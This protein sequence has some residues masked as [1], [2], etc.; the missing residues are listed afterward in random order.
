[1]FQMFIIYTNL[2]VFFLVASIVPWVLLH[3]YTWTA[4]IDRRSIMHDFSG[5]LNQHLELPTAFLTASIKIE[6]L[7]SS[8]KV[9]E[10]RLILL[11]KLLS[12][13]LIAKHPTNGTLDEKNLNASTMPAW[14]PIPKARPLVTMTS[15]WRRKTID[16]F[17]HISLITR[18]NI[19]IFKLEIAFLSQNDII[20]LYPSIIQSIHS[21]TLHHW[22]LAL[23]PRKTVP[24]QLCLCI[25]WMCHTGTVEA[26]TVQLCQEACLRVGQNCWEIT[27]GFCS[28]CFECL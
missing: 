14:V 15:A 8:L 28:F 16:S 1:M 23:Q 11:S 26:P 4:P 13:N 6:L 18:S 25:P 20:S 12:H 5:V 10:A 22:S 19:L 7:N 2:C 24:H 17:Q 21:S 9:L 3:A 27:I